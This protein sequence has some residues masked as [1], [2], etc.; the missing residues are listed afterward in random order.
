VPAGTP[1]ANSVPP[2]PRAGAPGSGIAT[3]AVAVLPGG[4]ASRSFTG[5]LTGGTVL[6]SVAPAGRW[7]LV[8]PD[9]T[10]TPRTSSF[11]WAARYRVAASGT[12]TLRF[13]GGLLSPLSFVLSLVTWLIAVALLLGDGAVRPWRRIRF[14][15]P[16][17]RAAGNAA[18][19][20]G[21]RG[22]GG[23]GG[24]PDD[25]VTPDRGTAT[26]VGSG[27]TVGGAVHR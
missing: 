20:D 13:D 7:S 3:G 10:R 26:G 5:P 4:I 18:D 9:G 23:D 21:E 16:R 11:G 24:A 1:V 8:G 25:P 15:R 2:D 19:G 17:A 22:D 27:A 14:P 6:A 12:G